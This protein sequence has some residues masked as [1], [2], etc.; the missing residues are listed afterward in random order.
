MLEKPFLSDTNGIFL[1]LHLEFALANFNARQRNHKG[2][3]KGQ[4]AIEREAIIAEHR[5]LIHSRALHKI[6]DQAIEAYEPKNPGFNVYNID[7][8]DG[9]KRKD[10]AQE[11]TAQVCR[12]QND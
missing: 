4:Q 7:K 9:T 1:F 12:C 2:Y 11:R 8:I 6:K 5:N 3:H 10:K